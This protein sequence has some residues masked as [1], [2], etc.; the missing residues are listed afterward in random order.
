[1]TNYATF[2]ARSPRAPPRKALIS[3]AIS[4]TL[5]L[6][7]ALVRFDHLAG[8]IVYQIAA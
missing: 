1:M 8:I 4:T 3:E 2:V 5:E 6:A 7:L